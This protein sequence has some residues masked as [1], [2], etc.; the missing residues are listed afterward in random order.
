MGLA[1][2]GFV[3]QAVAI[4][5]LVFAGNVPMEARVGRYTVDDWVWVRSDRAIF[6]PDLRRFRLGNIGL[7][8]FK[9]ISLLSLDQHEHQHP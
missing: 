5:L 3:E 2:V 4:S 7:V 1:Q 8:Y 9:R 6:D